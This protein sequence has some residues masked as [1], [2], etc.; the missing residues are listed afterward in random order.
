MDFKSTAYTNSATLAHKY[1][2]LLYK[3]MNPYTELD[4]PV[5][6]SLETIKQR[7]RTLAQMYHPDKGGDEEIFKRIKLA[8][9]IL[10]DPVRRK[11]YDITGETTTTNAKDEAVANIVQILLHV[12]P[13]FNVDQDDLI[14][15]AEMETRSMLDLVFKDI[16]VTE[17]YIVNLEKVSKKLRIKT[18]GEN[19]LNSFV[20]NQIQQRRQEL[21]TFQHRVRVCNLMLE[22]LKDYEYGLRVIMNEMPVPPENTGQSNE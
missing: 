9:E 13:S 19:L 4:V 18:E 11:Q 6:A 20:L 21:V 17:R 5:D 12:V 22:I 14:H 8:Y 7:Y 16:G 15:I 3:K 1:L 2:K 10:S